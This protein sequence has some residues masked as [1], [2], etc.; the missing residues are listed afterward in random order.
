[1][2]V[3][4]ELS[5]RRVK[6]AIEISKPWEKYD[7]MKAYRAVIPL[8]EQTPIWTEIEEHRRTVEEEH[9]RIRRRKLLETRTSTVS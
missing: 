5:K 4:F 2:I 9:R 8:E 1:M 3:P 7:L 6:R